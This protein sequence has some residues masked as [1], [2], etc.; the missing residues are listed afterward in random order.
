MD[1]AKW[2]QRCKSMYWNDPPEIYH[3]QD[4]PK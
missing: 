4:N 3:V 2:P 1:T